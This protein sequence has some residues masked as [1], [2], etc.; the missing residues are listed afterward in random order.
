MTPEIRF[1]KEMVASA[2]DDGALAEITT[3]RFKKG[4][5][6]LYW[7]YLELPALHIECKYHDMSLRRAA[8][9]PLVP[10]ETTDLQQL[11]LKTL[12]RFDV[13]AAVLIKV[14]IDKKSPK[15]YT[16]WDLNAEEIYLNQAP[17]YEKENGLWP[18]KKITES[19]LNL[20]NLHRA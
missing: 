17:C 13:V 16:V 10:V 8:F 15:V 3:H 6:D 9:E 14:T 18:I 5:P 2:K 20:H 19:L 1:Q 11:C 7:K 12:R 4:W